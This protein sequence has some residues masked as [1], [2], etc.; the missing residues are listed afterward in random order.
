[1]NAVREHSFYFSRSW[2]SRPRIHKPD[3]EEDIQEEESVKGMQGERESTYL[4]SQD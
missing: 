4:G 3:E 1:M 2:E